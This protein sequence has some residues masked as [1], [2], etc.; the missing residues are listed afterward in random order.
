MIFGLINCI[1]T[2]FIISRPTFLGMLPREDKLKKKSGTKIYPRSCDLRGKGLGTGFNILV[3]L[4][5]TLIQLQTFECAPFLT[6][7]NKQQSRKKRPAVFRSKHL[8]ALLN[9]QDTSRYMDWKMLFYL[10][11]FY[12]SNT[13]S[14]IAF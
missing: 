4:Y 11:N 3:I 13:I 10:V 2:S 5:A 8:D 14:M 7:S 6:R 9:M 1:L 12:Q